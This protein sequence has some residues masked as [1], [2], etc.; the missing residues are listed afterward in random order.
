MNCSFIEIC[1]TE[2]TIYIK[3]INILA[4]SVLSTPMIYGQLLEK[5]VSEKKQLILYIY[6]M[7]EREIFNYG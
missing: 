3:V 7:I 1:S 5:D 4:V 6:C 2:L